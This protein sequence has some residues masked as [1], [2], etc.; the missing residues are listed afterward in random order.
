MRPLRRIGIIVGLAVLA[1]WL[2]V[3]GAGLWSLRSRGHLGTSDTL[4]VTGVYRYVRHPLYAGLSLTLAGF[5]LVLG[6]ASLVL[7]GLG[8]LTVTQLWSIREERELARRFGAEYTTYR[9]FTPGV[10]P[11]VARFV[12]DLRPK[13]DGEPR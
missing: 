6:R 2:P 12:A 11:S 9:M 7:G 13:L 4:I 5:G 10:V 3:L 8:W 1:V